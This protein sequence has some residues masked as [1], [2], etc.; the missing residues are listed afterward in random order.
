MFIRPLPSRSGVRS[1]GWG[2][3]GW[4]KVRCSRKRVVECS[5]D[6]V[7]KMERVSRDESNET[8]SG[9][10]H[11]NPRRQKV[12]LNSQQHVKQGTHS[13]PPRLRGL[14]WCIAFRSGPLNHVPLSGGGCLSVRS[15]RNKKDVYR[16]QGGLNIQLLM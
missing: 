8:Y 1:R 12:L 4:A 5:N 14:T 13:A 15:Q 6:Q 9:G 7:I 10:L 3:S 11:S 2:C 16:A